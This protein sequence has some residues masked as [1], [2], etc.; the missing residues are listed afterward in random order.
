MPRLLYELLRCSESGKANQL[1]EELCDLNRKRQQL[2]TEIWEDAT[3]LLTDFPAGNPIVLESPSWHPGVVGIAASRL[4]EQFS[5]PA[6]MICLKD[7]I[8]KG[9]CRSYGSFNI[10]EALSAC[11]KYLI[12]FGGHAQAA[13]LTVQEQQLPAFKTALTEYYN[14]HLP[15]EGA[16]LSCDLLITDPSLLTKENVQALDLLEPFG[17]GNPTPVFCI[18]GAELCD[19]HPIGAGKHLRFRI[20]YNEKLLDCVYFSCTENQFGLHSG[21]LVDVAFHAKINEF[22]GTSSVQLQILSAKPHS[23]T[24]LCEKLIS[25]PSS[26]LWCCGD[27]CPSRADF[28]SAWK[29]IKSITGSLGGDLPALL[30]HC[31]GDLPEEKYILT[32]LVWNELGLIESSQS[33]SV[34]NTAINRNR[35]VDLEESDLLSKLKSLNKER[36]ADNV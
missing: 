17:N 7:G 18:S 20:K 13:G 12:S 6:I 10:F 8:G 2:E 14:H 34:L 28:I 26:V 4:A 30:Q 5:V 27:Y 29:N 19:V 3:R 35:K 23:P 21:D 24:E 25:D 11:S 16:V 32:L 1:A 22:N 31:P 15:E 36:G 33:D 9:S